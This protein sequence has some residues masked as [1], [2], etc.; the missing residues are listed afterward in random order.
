[1]PEDRNPFSEVMDSH[2]KD[3]NANEKFMNYFYQYFLYPKD[4][5]SFL[6]V[7]QILQALAIKTAVDHCRSNYGRCMGAVYW[8]F[9]DNWP[10]ASWSSI[11]YF[12]RWKMLQYAAKRF[13]APLAQNI[14]LN[15]NTARITLVN[16]HLTEK[17]YE[18]KLSICN[19]QN[20]ELWNFRHNGVIGAQCA[21][22]VL[23][24]D[25]TAVLGEYD[26]REIYL[27]SEIRSE[28]LVLQEVETVK[29]YKYLHL[30]KPDLKAEITERPDSFEIELQTDCFT[31][32]VWL[33]MEHADGIFSDNMLHLT[34]ARTK[35]TLDKKDLFEKDREL[36]LEELK[37]ELTVKCLQDSYVFDE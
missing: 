20:R 19:L 5:E 12:G 15:G 17:P 34:K 16:D 36:T 26:P 2:E 3:S 22:T 13:F 6:Y 8:Q 32:Y 31:P 29:R 4:F 21:E 9:N 23:E 11:D 24:K 18:L 25:L 10:V 35:V 7:T 30:Q 27:L 1:M 37:K 28:D 14:L 33:D